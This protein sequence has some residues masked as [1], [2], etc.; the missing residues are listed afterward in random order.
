VTPTAGAWLIAMHEESS[1]QAPDLS[2]AR[3]QV[4]RKDAKSRV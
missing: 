4:T 2:P 3:P 1:D